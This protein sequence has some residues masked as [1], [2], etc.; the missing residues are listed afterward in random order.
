MNKKETIAM[1]VMLMI[2]IAVKMPNTE[3]YNN[4]K[5][6]NISNYQKLLVSG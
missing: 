6:I 5:E 2:I 4:R 1:M 3:E